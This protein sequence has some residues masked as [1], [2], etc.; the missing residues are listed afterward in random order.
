MA[1]PVFTQKLFSERGLHVYAKYKSFSKKKLV[2]YFEEEIYV[3]AGLIS[4]SK[5]K[6]VF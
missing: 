5:W 4:F 1:H 3:L 6:I 2:S